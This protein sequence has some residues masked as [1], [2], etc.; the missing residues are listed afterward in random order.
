[1]N[2]TAR[3][4]RP[5]GF[6]CESGNGTPGDHELRDGSLVDVTETARRAGLRVAT[7][8][9]ASLY[10]DISDLSS[11]FRGRHDRYAERLWDVLF[12]GRHEAVKH[13]GASFT[14]RVEMPVGG[15]RLVTVKAVLSTGGKAPT[16]TLMRP[17]ED[18]E[19]GKRRSWA[20]P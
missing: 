18:P 1:M 17:G 5:A 8:I 4:G 6:H 19:P 9:T 13:G 20:S 11:P 7:A 12:V 15:E 3:N 16:L 14:Y 2:G 10:A